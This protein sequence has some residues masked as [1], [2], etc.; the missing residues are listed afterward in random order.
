MFHLPSKFQ[1]G[2]G[3]GWYVA[4]WPGQEVELSD[5]PRLPSLVVLQ[6][7]RPHQVVLAPDVLRHQVDLG[8]NISIKIENTR[9][10]S[11]VTLER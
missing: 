5:R 9:R 8:R 4:V 11:E 3:A 10:D 6:V 7:E 1:D 2:L